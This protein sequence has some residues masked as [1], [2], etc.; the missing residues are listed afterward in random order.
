MELLRYQARIVR[1]LQ[2]GPLTFDE[3]LSQLS[4]V[5]RTQLYMQIRNMLKRKL[6]E[7]I[8]GATSVKFGAL[9][10]NT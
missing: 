2:A 6:I 3:L 4:G 8:S 10:V 9:H 1:A 7:K 5:E